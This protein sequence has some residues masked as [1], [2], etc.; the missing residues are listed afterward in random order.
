MAI[1]IGYK[2]I[3]IYF[4]WRGAISPRLYLAIVCSAIVL[5]LPSFKVLQ[6]LLL[7]QLL[8]RLFWLSLLL[9]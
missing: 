9:P 5:F 8:L 3:Q 7:P 1:K 4:Y 2:D 6:T